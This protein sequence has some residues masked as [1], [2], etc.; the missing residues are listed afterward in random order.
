MI[1]YIY[2]FNRLY[3]PETN[4]ETIFA[5]ISIFIMTGVFGYSLNTIGGLVT[6]L[7]KKTKE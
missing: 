2:K 4:T 7:N 5:V 6:E 1:Y 3:I